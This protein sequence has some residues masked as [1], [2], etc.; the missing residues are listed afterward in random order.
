MSLEHSPVDRRTVLRAAGTT[1]IVASVA[2]CTDRGSLESDGSDDVVLPP[3]DDYDEAIAEATSYPTYGDEIPSVAV[4]APLRDE[5]V[6]TTAFVDDRHAL[7]T[8]L[9]TRCPEVCPGLMAALRHVQEDSIEEGYVDDVALCPITFDPVYD[10]PE[11]LEAY[12]R[13]HG[14]DQDA[15]NWYTLRPETESD[16]EDVVHEAF[17]IGFQSTDEE[18]GNG[19][20]DGGHDH[21][22]DD[23]GSDDHEHD[24]HEMAFIHSNLVLLV[25]RD[26][27]VERAY[28][29]D[30]PTAATVLEDTRTVREGW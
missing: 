28:F 14:V 23:Y 5:T 25:N 30:V 10:T 27:Y 9:F 16:A 4:P 29:G 20:T 24:D 19:D 26:G 13:D 6:M 8:F 2:G 22:E 7:Y 1:A 12:E 21:D 11:V 3:P 15:G 17:G 18:A